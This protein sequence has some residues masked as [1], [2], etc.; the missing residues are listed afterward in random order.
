MADVDCFKQYND[1]YGHAAGDRCLQ[2]VAA[3]LAEVIRRPAD[4]LARYGGEEFVALLPQTDLQ[5]AY[6]TAERMRQAVQHLCIPHDFSVVSPVVTVSLGITSAIPGP[7]DPAAALVEA[8]DRALYRA[9]HE[10]RNRVA[11]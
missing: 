1:N 10:G 2:S 8:A 4:F 6:G 5:G 7:A 9:K 11:V 3:S